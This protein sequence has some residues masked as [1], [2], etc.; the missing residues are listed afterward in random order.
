MQQ[1]HTL[2]RHKDIQAWVVDRHGLPAVSRV[3][4]RFGEIKPRLTI[5]FG[6]PT[7]PDHAP[8]LDDGVSPVSWSAWLAELDR[9]QLA[10]KVSPDTK[11]EFVARRD[12]N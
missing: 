8:S 5:Q 4:D 11:F 7:A 6:R 3:S 1:S 9:Q 2:T 12:L 10:L